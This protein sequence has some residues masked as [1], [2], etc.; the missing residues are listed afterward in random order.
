[1]SATPPQEQ[2]N[3]YKGNPP[4]AWLRCRLLAP[5]SLAHDLDCMV[6]TGSPYF[7][8][9]GDHLMNLLGS[10]AA[11]TIPTNFGP[12]SGGWVRLTIPD[13]GFDQQ[14][15]GFAS[16]VVIASAQ[17]SCPDFE[18]VVGLPLLRMHTYGGDDTEFWLRPLGSTP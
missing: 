7:L 4:K 10:R 6:D 3:P 9:I 12:L 17:Q 11:V 5:A 16:D 1:M 8:V 14:L 15:L 13:V 18:G 2:R